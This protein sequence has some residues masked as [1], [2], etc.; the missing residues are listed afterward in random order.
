MKLCLKIKG[1]LNGSLQHNTKKCPTGGVCPLLGGHP[2]I[3]I[4]TCSKLIHLAFVFMHAAL[5]VKEGAEFRCWGVRYAWEILR[6]GRRH[7]S[8][9]D[10]EVQP[11]SLTPHLQIL[12]QE[13]QVK[14]NKFSVSVFLWP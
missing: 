7:F 5:L 12:P 14:K 8:K 6:C 11:H 2:H 13:L 9:L 4:D 1:M 10:A 3:V